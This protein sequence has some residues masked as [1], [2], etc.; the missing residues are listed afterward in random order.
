M[1]ELIE[2][3]KKL[4]LVDENSE[5]AELLSRILRSKY[6]CDRVETG[7]SALWKLKQKEYSVV[8]CNAALLKS[9]SLQIIPQMQMIAPHSAIVLLGEKI[10][11]EDTVKIFRAGAFDYLF[12]PLEFEQVETAII[13]AT[14][15][16]EAKCLKD[17]YQFHLENLAAERATEIDKALEEVESSYR[18]TLKA[19]VQALET[20]DFETH[21]HSERVVTF[22]LRLGYELGLEKEA[23]RDL[24][25]GAL[26]HDIGKIGVPDAILRKPARLN[27]EEW[28]KMKLHPLH[29]QKIL[30]SIKFL[31]GAARV[32]G[33]HHERW[34]GE[35]YPFGLRGED[36]DIG[37]RI[38]AVV[39]AF[40]AMISDRVY[41]K[42][43]PFHEALE[44]LERCSGTQFDPLVVEAFKAIPKEDWEILRK[45]SLMEKQE[46]SSFQSVVAELV[47]SRQQFEMVH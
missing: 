18:I 35:G 13:R 16:Y 38:F 1:F 22:S 25:L 10:S 20:R 7:E 24:E 31:E 28:T 40:D 47:Y 34:D 5:T 41:R 2:T 45:R 32:V 12:K 44:E 42:G 43:R 36:I 11:A 15:H 46:I 39:D 29:G 8:L 23:L 3:E 17:R 37:A 14:E 21:G 9:E 6:N 19:L 30:R 4:L 33:Q 26:L 27:E